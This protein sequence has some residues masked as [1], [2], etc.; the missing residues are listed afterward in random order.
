M[1]RALTLLTAIWPW[2]AKQS[3]TVMAWGVQWRSANALDGDKTHLMGSLPWSKSPTM[4]ETRREARAWI[5]VTYGYIA[6]RPDL[7]AEPHGWKMPR[8]VRVRVTRE[9]VP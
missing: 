6:D 3:R 8:A 2:R 7:R 9:V 4:F 1:T 5:S